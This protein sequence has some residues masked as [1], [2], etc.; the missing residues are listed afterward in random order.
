MSKTHAATAAPAGPPVNLNEIVKNLPDA[1]RA[2]HWS[3]AFASD[4][5]LAQ[6]GQAGNLAGR[7]AA[8]EAC[9][10]SR[11]KDLAT[12]F[13]PGS[14]AVQEAM[15]FTE[16]AFACLILFIVPGAALW[17]PVLEIGLVIHA[18]ITGS[19]AFLLSVTAILGA[20]SVLSPRAA[21]IAVLRSRAA[22]LLLKYFSFKIVWAD[23][24]D[25]STPNVLSAP[26]HGAFPMGNL[27][28]MISSQVCCDGWGGCVSVE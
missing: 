1:Q 25:P 6:T 19:Y 18:I 26:P 2:G 3:W 8:V 21:S 10:R 14:L 24:L 4:V 7:T 22:L 28:T 17:I 23:R 16:E 12:P 15:T 11:T 5:F 13:P 27:L 20:I 9:V